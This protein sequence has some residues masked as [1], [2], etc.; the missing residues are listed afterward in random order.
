[1]SLKEIAKRQLF[2]C[3]EAL[4]NLIDK[5]PDNIWNQKKGGY[6]FWQQILHAMNG[7]LYWL[8]TEKKDF[9]EPFSDLNLY[10]ELEKDPENVLSKEQIK[11]LHKQVIELVN[12]FFDKLNSNNL[13]EA[14]VLNDKISNLDIVFD[15]IRH[16]QYHIG[17][18]ESILREAGITDLKW[19]ECYSD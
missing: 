10:P 15:Q 9:T 14:S 16:L 3:F 2:L 6:V 18:C 19:L 11:D 12:S 4:E 5:T 13:L 7:S 17:H 8:R 1:M